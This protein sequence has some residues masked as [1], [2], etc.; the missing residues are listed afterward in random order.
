MKSKVVVVIV[1]QWQNFNNDKSSNFIYGC[2]KS[3]TK[4]TCKGGFIEGAYAP[5][6]KFS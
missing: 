6:S 3:A 4:F 2:L 5:P 1:G